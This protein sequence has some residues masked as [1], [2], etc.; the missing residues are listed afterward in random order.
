MH[1]AKSICRQVG[2]NALIDLPGYCQDHEHIHSERFK[3]L[4]KSPGSR[5]F[6][7]SGKWVK[8]RNAYIAAHPLCADHQERGLIVKADLVDHIV[9]RNV[10]E[11]RGDDPFNFMWLQSLCH[12]CHN[13]KLRQRQGVR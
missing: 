9:D 7:G 4:R 3:G 6:Y 8:T 11:A 10:L 13:K 1:N 5:E 2:C 12:S